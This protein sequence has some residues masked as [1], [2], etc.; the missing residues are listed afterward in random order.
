MRFCKNCNNMYYLKME[1]GDDNNL[2][3]Y[4]RNCGNEDI[5]DNNATTVMKTIVNGTND[6]YVNIVNEY[7]KHDNTIPRVKEIKC[8][9]SSCKS[10]DD[11]SI[12]EILL[13][14]HD[15]TNMKYVYLC[16]V[17]DYVWKSNIK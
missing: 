15:E 11:D 13:L 7:T 8:A 14:R 3:Y 10:R 1:S 6:T 2:V 17:C 16:A 5:I 12:N 9:N 4:C